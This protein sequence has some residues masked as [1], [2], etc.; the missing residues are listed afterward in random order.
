MTL[1]EVFGDS[2]SFDAAAAELARQQVLTAE[3]KKRGPAV[4]RLARLQKALERRQSESGAS[5]E[6]DA[7]DDVVIVGDDDAEDGAKQALVRAQSALEDAKKSEAGG[8]SY[9][10]LMNLLVQLRKW[11]VQSS[12]PALVPR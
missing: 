8:G 2:T 5:S 11:C 4:A 3:G 9:Q 1:G 7:D 12:L 6:A 10:K